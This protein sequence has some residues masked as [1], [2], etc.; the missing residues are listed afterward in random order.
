MKLLNDDITKCDEGLIIHGVNCQGVMGSGI[1][2]SIKRKWP[3]IY[4]RF[5]QKGKGKHL[6][7]TTQIIPI[8]DDCLYVANCFTQEKYGRDGKVYASL[9]AIEKS[10]NDIFSFALHHNLTIH[11]P[12]IGCGLGG[13]K[14]NDVSRIYKN[15]I[16]KYGHEDVIIYYI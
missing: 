15:M 6:L 11:S 5:K 1:A 7:G 12:K 3:I 9:D 10:L 14:W 13:L 4:Q 2:K 8:N 16:L